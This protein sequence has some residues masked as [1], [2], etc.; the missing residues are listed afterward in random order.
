MLGW[1]SNLVRG[2][3]E[4][5][6]AKPA[7]TKKSTGGGVLTPVQLPKVKSGQQSVPSYFRTAKPDTSSALP[8]TDSAI[9]N[10][11]LET[12]RTGIDSRQVMRD[13]A[14]ASP[15]LSA[16]VNAYLRTAITPGYTAVAKNMD[17]TFSR[18]GT[19]LLQQ[20]L[21]RFDVVQD[22][23]DGFS[24]ISSLRSTSESLA[25]EGLFYGAMSMELVL[26]KDRLPR[27]FAP[28]SVTQIKFF[29]DKSGKW[30]RPIQ[31]LGGLQIDLDQ[32][33]FFYTALDQSLL[34]AYATSPLEPALQPVLAQ[35]SFM[36]D[37]RRV[38]K[39][40]I[41]PR[42]TV[43]INWEVFNKQMPAQAKASQE[44]TS[45]YMAQMLTSIEN[46]IN[47]LNPEDVLVA[48]DTLQFA[49]LNNGN[50]SLKDEYTVLGEMMDAKT[51]TGAKVLPSILGH[52]AGTQSIAS[53]ETLLFMK[54]AEGTTQL[55][56]NEI[57]SRALTLAVR[58]YGLDVY[59]EFKYD[60][61][62]LR[63]AAELEAFKVMKQ[64]RILEQLSYGFITDDEAAMELTGA[65]TP[66]GFTPLS[67]T[68]FFNPAPVVASG[69][70]SAHSNTGAAGKQNSKPGTPTQSKGPQKAD[71]YDINQGV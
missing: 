51:A 39:R 67:G 29:P 71:L 23:T 32:P 64:S 27:G 18:D 15:D 45:A 21:T 59:V 37:L 61:I 35:I 50:S 14:A 12:Y 11:D 7:S 44:A 17:G 43:E 13:F 70:D 8:R 63:P 38:V 34:D 66:V 53:S 30:L 24:G 22:Y 49:Y 55:K 68:G 54:N 52:G 57:Y 69:K 46:K 1:L 25:K 65:L 58:L 26:G 62:D 9:V 3:P 33:T 40:A 36:N 5:D 41:H 31:L 6:A 48:F 10:K 47:G 56:L 4:I 2:A 16:A 20:L 42:M 19:T 28:I 60:T